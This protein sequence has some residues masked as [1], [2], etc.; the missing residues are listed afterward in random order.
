VS[1]FRVLLG[2]TLGHI[3]RNPASIIPGM[4]REFT[5]EIPSVRQGYGPYTP[6]HLPQRQRDHLA[7][8][9]PLVPGND[10]HAQNARPSRILD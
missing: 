1:A 3:L 8:Q 7:W 10:G 5:D 4:C 2:E 9:R 6:L